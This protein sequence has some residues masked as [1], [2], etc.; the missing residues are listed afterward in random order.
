MALSTSV[1]LRNYALATGPVR[2]AIDLGFIHI[3]SGIPPL[4]ADDAI[5]SQGA[6]VL[7]VTIS[8]DATATGVSM[9]VTASSGTLE[10]DTAQ[11]WRGTA[12]NT[13]LA[14][15][16]RHVGP[17]DTGAGTTTE[18]RYQGLVAQAGAEL[19]MSDP[20]I[21]A[22]ADQKIDFYLINLPS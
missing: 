14:E 6:N 7:L 10:K 15:W 12:A 5:N 11:I 19:N 17:A 2:D 22:G 4:T 13:G 3:Y 20:N 9:S 8:L 18:P 21:I 16:Y 1:G